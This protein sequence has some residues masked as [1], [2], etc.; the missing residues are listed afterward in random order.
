[1]KRKQMRKEIEKKSRFYIMTV[2]GHFIEWVDVI[3][4]CDYII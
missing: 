3:Y 2:A 4:T 1:M